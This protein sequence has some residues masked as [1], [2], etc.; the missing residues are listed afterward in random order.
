MELPKYNHI[1]IKITSAE[2][3]EF[4]QKMGVKVIS[5]KMKDYTVY[6]IYA[7]TVK[8]AEIALKD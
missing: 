2:E 8:L 3:A 1:R 6:C 5:Q 4:F 7:P